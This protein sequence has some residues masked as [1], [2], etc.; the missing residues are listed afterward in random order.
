MVSSIPQ[1]SASALVDRLRA[2]PARRGGSHW[3]STGKTQVLN[4]EVSGRWSRISRRPVW[5]KPHA[6][7]KLSLCLD[8]PPLIQHADCFNNADVKIRVGKESLGEFRLR[9]HTCKCGISQAG[10]RGA[11]GGQHRTQSS[12][13]GRGCDCYDRSCWGQSGTVST[14]YLFLITCDCTSSKFT[15]PTHCFSMWTFPQGKHFASPLS[16]F[17][18]AGVE[19]TPS[20]PFALKQVRRL[21]WGLI[22][23]VGECLLWMFPPFFIFN[24]R[25][26]YSACL[27]ELRQLKR[28]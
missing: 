19:R 15:R 11:L 20:F 8:I 23:T 21:C 18:L 1:T 14:V 6:W 12:I 22:G 7:L 5:C 26:P 9:L 25:N 10:E 24:K 3:E 4:T 17:L 28:L 16:D 27:L 13:R 2:G